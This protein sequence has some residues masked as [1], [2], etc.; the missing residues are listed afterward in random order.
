MRELHA[1]E[2]A[3]ERLRS[4]AHGHHV[5]LSSGLLLELRRRGV[6]A[7]CMKQIMGAGMLSPEDDIVVGQCM[8]FYGIATAVNLAHPPVD[9]CHRPDPAT[10]YNRRSRDCAR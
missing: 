8:E 1:R 6:L 9:V 7:E 3:R 4:F 10:H 2:S 5:V